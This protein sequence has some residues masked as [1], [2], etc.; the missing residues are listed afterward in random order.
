MFECQGCINAKFLYPWQNV[1][2]TILWKALLIPPSPGGLKG[3]E[4]Q[5]QNQCRSDTRCLAVNLQGG[6]PLNPLILCPWHL[7][8]T[9]MERI[10]ALVPRGC[11]GC[12]DFTI[13]GQQPN[14]N[15]YE[16]N[17]QDERD[18]G[19]QGSARSTVST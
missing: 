8:V 10:P 7:A 1:A 4:A 17:R 11:A 2:I 14:I 9:A 16:I 6:S 5:K 3:E 12:K 13:S 19:E 18:K 15:A